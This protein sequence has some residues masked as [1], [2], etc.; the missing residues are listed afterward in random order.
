[1]E[2]EENALPERA[3]VRR[4]EHARTQQWFT[5]MQGV[6]S[7]KSATST[8]SLKGRVDDTLW[9]E[10]SAVFD[11]TKAYRY[12]LRRVWDQGRGVL[13][14]VLLNPSTADEAI[15]DPTIRRCVGYA[16]RWGFGGVEI[17]NLFA[18]RSTDPYELYAHPDPVGPGNDAALLAAAQTAAG[19]IMIAGW[20]IHGA[21]NGRD[22]QVQ[23]LIASTGA[24]LMCLGKTKGQQPRHPLYLKSDAVLVPV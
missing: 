22:A 1:M 3:C 15:L 2:G 11:P 23:R 20:G 24:N 4:R 21:F 10:S 19:G 18:L 13:P 16:Q 5:E 6:R 7:V 12:R 14:W 9:L 8:R 17:L